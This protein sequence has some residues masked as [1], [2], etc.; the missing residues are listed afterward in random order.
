MFVKTNLQLEKISKITSH[1]HEMTHKKSS[2]N[3]KIVHYAPQHS[4]Q[5]LSFNAIR[6]CLAYLSEL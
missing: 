1:I 2:F 6:V 4:A 5:F 3:I